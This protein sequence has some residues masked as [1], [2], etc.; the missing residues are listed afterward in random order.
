MLR[1]KNSKRNGSFSVTSVCVCVVSFLYAVA[2]PVYLCVLSLDLYP[3]NIAKDSEQS[4][5]EKLKRMRAEEKLK[6]DAYK[7]VGCVPFF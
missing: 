4:Y 1:K 5:L 3:S 6:S 7:Q 2:R